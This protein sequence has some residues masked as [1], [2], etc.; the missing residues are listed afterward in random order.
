[1]STRTQIVSRTLLPVAIA[2][3]PLVLLFSAIRTFREVDEQ[4]AIYLR[5]RVALLAGRLENLPA[6][7]TPDAV[8]ETVSQDEPYLVDVQVIVRGS[9]AD[10]A[11]LSP[12]WDGRELFRTITARRNGVTL[13]RAYVPFHSGEGLRVACIDLNAEAADFLVVHARHNVIVASVSGLVLVVLSI[14]SLWA[15]RR[16]AQLRERQLAMEHLVHIGKM[17]AALAHEIRNPLGTIKGFVQLAAERADAPTRDL[18]TPVLTET[19][20]LEALVSDLLAYGRP[21]HPEPRLTE[22]SEVTSV[23]GAHA[24][25]LIGERPIHLVTSDAALQLQTDPALLGQALLNLVRNAIEAIPPAAEGEVRIEAYLALRGGVTI[26]V[27][28]TGSGISN[29][30]IARLFEP[31]FTTKAFGTGLG[32]AITRGVVKALGGEL[33][34]RRRP[35][36]GSQATIRMPARAA[37]S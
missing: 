13:F 1:V 11:S 9:A 22:W 4:R 28:D 7:T 2:A 36:G 21:P 24:R 23:L 29:D 19:L 33:E 20:R 27:T 5:H 34:L 10:V 17:A 3:L 31:F 32:L 30:A 25:Q 6:G 37:M 15:M 8:F 35:E 12:L 18:L 16:A 14:Y 26:S